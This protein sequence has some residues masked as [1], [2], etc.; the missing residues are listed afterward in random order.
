MASWFLVLATLFFAVVYALPLLFIPLRW[1]RWFAWE[2]QTGNPDLTV[3]FGRCLGGVALAVILTIIRGIP[4]PA[5]H[6]LLFEL[7]FFVTGMMTLVH[8]WG[9]IRKQQPWPE[10]VEIGL[11]G[12]V[13]VGA[14]WIRFFTLA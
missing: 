5:S 2:P 4:D 8:I 13:A 12:A 1:S 10:T 7:I 11:Y 14:F 9:A 3:Y 6:K